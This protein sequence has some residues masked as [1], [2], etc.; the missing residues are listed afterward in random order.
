ML[1]LTHRC[2]G[3]R[4]AVAAMADRRLVEAFEMYE[5]LMAAPEAPSGTHQVSQQ[6]PE[7]PLL[8]SQAPLKEEEDFWFDER[9]R[10]G[11]AE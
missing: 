2:S 5:R 10:Y 1:G 7:Q 11:C 6:S 4:Q 9:L 3:T 8:G